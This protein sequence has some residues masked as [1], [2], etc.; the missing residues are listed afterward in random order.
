MAFDDACKG[1]YGPDHPEPSDG[2]NTKP[3]CEPT[4]KGDGYCPPA[5]A[6]KTCQPYQLTKSRD[7]CFIDNLTNEALNIGGADVNVYKLLGVH[8]QCKTVDVT[9]KGSA[10]SNGAAPGFPA[11][12]A[13]DTFVSEWRSVQKG[14]GV[15]ASAYIGYDF[16]EI[17]TNDDS[18]EMY[19]IETSVRKHITAIAIK[20]GELS[21]NRVT[22]ARIERSEDGVK[23]YGVAV[24]NL[25]DDDCLNTI[26][27]R[28]SVPNRYWRIRPVTFN[29]GPNDNWA[30]QAIQM[31]HNHI[32]TDEENIQDKILLEN[33]DRD[34]AD[35]PALLKGSYD[36]I[37]ITT[38]LSKFG[39]ELP[40][41]QIYMTVNFN[42]CVAVI[43]RPLIIG[44][45]VELPSEAQWSAE[46]RK[47]LKWL[48]VTD[49]SWSTEGYT[50]GWQPTLLRVIL[51]PAFASQ[52]TQDIFGDLAEEELPDELGLVDKGDGRHAHYQDYS[53]IS[54]T[55][56][57]DAKDM[58]PEAGRETSGTI[59]AWEQEEIESAASQGVLNLQKIGQ[60]NNAVYTEDAMPPNNAPFSRGDA[61]PDNPSHGDYHR[62]EYTGLSKDVP[63]RLYRYS[64]SKG[65]WLFLEKDRRAEF[66]PN[67]PKLQEFLTAPGRISNTEIVTPNPK[68]CE[69]E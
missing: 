38:E 26:L 40:S 30:V 3:G 19:G 52:E 23:W 61:F 66:D 8:E 63:A 20:Q 64:S 62:M 55:I 4:A 12:Q 37:D 45:I 57:A 35:D 21:K 34:Y 65:R 54:Q 36:L 1:T 13:Y 5:G 18:R 59:R 31:F 68:Q 17:K 32:A 10:I 43:G 9:G 33:R 60:N 49:V 39:I 46:M 28:D 29:G 47:I 53:D 56:I 15:T 48:E 16:G 25:P 27:F 58:V 41:Q 2:S 22:R 50:P 44:D 7:N 14:D 67:K 6:D 24:V 11:S 42:S 69:D 51:Q